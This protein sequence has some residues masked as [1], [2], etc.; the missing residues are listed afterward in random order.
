MKIDDFFNIFHFQHDVVLKCAYKFSTF[1]YYNKIHQNSNGKACLNS[2]WLVIY[3]LYTSYTCYSFLLCQS[4]SNFAITYY[5]I[6]K[7]TIF[8]LFF[9]FLYVFFYLC[10]KLDHFFIMFLNYFFFI[11]YLGANKITR[12]TPT[13]FLLLLWLLLGKYS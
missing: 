6:E 10:Q 8:L 1:K 3:Y 12:A 13:C 4:F 5:K 2:I 11:L 7:K 9:Y